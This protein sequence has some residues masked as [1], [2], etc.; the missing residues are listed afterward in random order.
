MN[1]GLRSDRRLTKRASNANDPGFRSMLIHRGDETARRVGVAASQRIE[2]GCLGTAATFGTSAEG[3][4]PAPD[5]TGN[6]TQIPNPQSQAPP[7]SN[8]Q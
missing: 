6:D 7:I 8:T 4:A 3:G 5:A 1:E 2:R